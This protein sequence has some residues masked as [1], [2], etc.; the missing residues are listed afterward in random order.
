MAC[1]RRL[2]L[3]WPRYSKGLYSTAQREA[4]SAGR[5]M[6]AGSYVEPWQYRICVR[7]GGRPADCSDDATAHP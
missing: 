6:W 3:D 2:A 7:A 4:A 1:Q 5:G